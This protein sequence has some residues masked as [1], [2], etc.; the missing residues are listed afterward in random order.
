MTAIGT[1]LRIVL[2][3]DAVEEVGVGPT[4]LVVDDDVKFAA[5]LRR[6]LNR[7]GFQVLTVDDGS[8]VEETLARCPVDALVLDLQMPGMNGF[9]VIRRL[10]GPLSTGT[11]RPKV[12]V[13]SGR[14]ET[15]TAAFVT[16][17]GADAFLRKPMGAD[18]LVQTLR[19]VLAQ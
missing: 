10:H 9:E 17:L 19:E 14:S 1:S 5:L 15:E 18:K 6:A 8:E 4:V 12:V 7:G 3:S 11:K 2:S 13:L 16:R